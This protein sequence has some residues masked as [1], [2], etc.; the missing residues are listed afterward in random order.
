MSAAKTRTTKIRE[1]EEKNTH[2]VKGAVG[3]MHSSTTHKQKGQQ[4]SIRT[5]KRFFC[6]NNEGD[7]DEKSQFTG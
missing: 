3:I 4:V 7:E 1:G 6:E 5:K 2:R